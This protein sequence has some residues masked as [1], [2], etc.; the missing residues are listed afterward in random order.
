MRVKFDAY[1]FTNLLFLTSAVEIY[2]HRVKDATWNITAWTCQSLIK[3]KISWM[4]AWK[5]LQ[6]IEDKVRPAGYP[7]IQVYAG[8]ALEDNLEV[9]EVALHRCNIFCICTSMLIPALRKRNSE[10]LCGKG[11]G[12]FGDF[13]Y[14]W[15]GSLPV[16]FPERPI[17]KGLKIVLGH[18]FLVLRLNLS[19]LEQS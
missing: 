7:V 12:G 6:K 9:V 5:G 8:R 10:T 13:L 18:L 11:W 4:T 17:E 3:A 19:A 14:P 15:S 2:G 16:R 1:T